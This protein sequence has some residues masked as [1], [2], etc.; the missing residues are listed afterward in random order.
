MNG[1]FKWLYDKA[2]PSRYV[3]N[4]FIDRTLPYNW[5]TETLYDRFNRFG[6][7]GKMVAF[8]YNL[9]YRFVRAAFFPDRYSSKK[10]EAAPWAPRFWNNFGSNP[11][12]IL[13]Q[14]IV[15]LLTQVIVMPLRLLAYSLEFIFKL[16]ITVAKLATN[17]ALFIPSIFYEWLGPKGFFN[18]I[19]FSKAL[20]ITTDRIMDSIDDISYVTALFAMRLVI[21]ILN[22]IMS[23]I[24]GIADVV[25][26]KKH[27]DFNE[28]AYRCNAHSLQIRLDSEKFMATSQAQGTEVAEVLTSTDVSIGNRLNARIIKDQELRRPEPKRYQRL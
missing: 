27:P 20:G 13:P 22:P 12:T 28:N 11:W 25:Y 23:P 19:S 26:R 16:L 8:T 15:G 9:K 17:I 24:M 1:L 10:Y 18:D 7:F 5:H 4:D 2:E 14:L 6:P 3:K 21:T